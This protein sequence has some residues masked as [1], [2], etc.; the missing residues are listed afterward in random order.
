MKNKRLDVIKLFSDS[1]LSCSKEAQAYGKCIISKTDL[2]KNDCQKEFL[3]FYNCY[4]V[5]TLII[6]KPDVI[7]SYHTLLKINKFIQKNNFSVVK[8]KWL[9]WSLSDA[10]SFYKQHTKKFFHTRLSMHMSSDIIQA[11]ILKYDR[12]GNCIEI[13]RNFLGNSKVYKSVNDFS[14]DTI[15]KRYAL[16]DTRNAIHASDSYESYLREAQFIFPGYELVK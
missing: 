6:F 11:Q 16:S 12:T 3:E 5:K 7:K 13:F 10:E 8:S 15:R 2:K 1:F 14:I 4:S 9:Q